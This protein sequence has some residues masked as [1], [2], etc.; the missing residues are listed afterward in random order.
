VDS[1][2]AQLRASS[3]AAGGGAGHRR[4]DDR[5]TGIPID[6]I[7][8]FSRASRIRARVSACSSSWWRGGGAC[9]CTLLAGT[10]SLEPPQPAHVQAVYERSDFRS[11][12]GGEQCGA[13]YVRATARHRKS[14]KKVQTMETD[15][16]HMGRRC[17]PHSSISPPLPARIDAR[18]HS[19]GWC[20]LPS[21]HGRRSR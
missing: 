9:T 15:A 3:A 7:S 21:N 10:F 2:I 5:H 8:R 4:R 13:V 12:H 14:L 20:P 11:Y 18:H 16:P 19:T 1:D 6:G 17:S